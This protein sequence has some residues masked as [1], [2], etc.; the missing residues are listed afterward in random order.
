M[1]PELLK[2]V[3]AVMATH[4]RRERLG[5]QARDKAHSFCSCGWEPDE[6]A[7][8]TRAFA[9][10][11]GSERTRSAKLVADLASQWSNH[12]LDVV[13]GAVADWLDFQGLGD[14]CLAT[15]MMRQP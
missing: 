4:E 15:H 10:Q 13:L 2:A 7:A 3:K 5:V 14:E 9:G 6:E 1:N 8:K 12:T 11:P